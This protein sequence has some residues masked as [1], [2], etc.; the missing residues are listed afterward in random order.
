M[1][2]TTTGPTQAQQLAANRS[3]SIN[4]LLRGADQSAAGAHG[5]FERLGPRAA[6]IS[7]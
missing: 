5:P 7:T 6:S 3:K 1:T 4:D 2:T